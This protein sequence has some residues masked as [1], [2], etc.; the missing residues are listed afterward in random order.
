MLNSI[1]LYLYV[2]VQQNRKRK[3]LFV[4]IKNKQAVQIESR[5]KIKAIS[6]FLSFC[7][8]SETTKG[9]EKKTRV[10]SKGKECIP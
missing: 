4:Q 7:L 6:F 9:R 10:Q 5:S 3:N 8:C 1:S 2:F